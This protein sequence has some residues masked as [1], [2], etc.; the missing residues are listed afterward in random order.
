MTYNYSGSRHEGEVRKQYAVVIYLPELLERFVAPLRER[1][2]PDYDLISAHITLVFPWET[3]VPLAE[4]SAVLANEALRLS[5]I[6]IELRSVGDF[7]P[8]TP[9]L[10]W[11]VV[12]NPQLNRLYRSLYA[13]LGL[14]L[15]F[16]EIVPHVTVAKEI[17]PHRV[18]LVKDQI[19][20][21]LPRES[22]EATALDLV[23][24]LADNKW[25]S[26]RTFPLAAVL[27]DKR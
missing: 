11:N 9:I 7:Y 16:K 25:V 2:D 15:P 24:P 26:V 27:P 12:A 17:S 23:S 5:P 4:L 6:K 19:A 22:F 3:T 14:S 13:Q 20:S 1:F 21:Y 10:Y 18:M 8:D